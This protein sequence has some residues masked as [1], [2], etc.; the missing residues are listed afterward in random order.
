MKNPSIHQHILR[1]VKI[2]KLLDERFSLFGFKFGIDPLLGLLPGLG[3]SLSLL[4]SLYLLWIARQLE[5]PTETIIKMI[6]N[7]GIDY[8][9]GIIPVVGDVADFFYKANL[10]NMELLRKYVPADLISDA[11][12]VEEKKA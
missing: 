4:F 8:V 7:L 2:S 9:V 3:D 5:V 11:E 10:K 1:A 6:R 12:I